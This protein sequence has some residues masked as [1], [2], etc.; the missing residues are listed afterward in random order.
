M[1]EEI[2]LKEFPLV[3]PMYEK[4]KRCAAFFHGVNIC[5]VCESPCDWKPI[6]DTPYKK[7][8]YELE[9]YL[10]NQGIKVE[11]VYD[12]NDVNLRSREI[13]TSINRP[14]KEEMYADILHELNLY[15]C[16][17]SL[18]YMSVTQRKMRYSLKV[19]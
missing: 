8:T 3:V 17:I 7:D 10:K 11:R 14:S 9:M 6:A 16:G 5:P 12:A 4:C 13:A 1:E 2:S 15:K 18:Y 19:D